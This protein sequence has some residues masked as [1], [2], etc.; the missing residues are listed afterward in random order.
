MSC[1]IISSAFSA[2]GTGTG[3]VSRADCLDDNKKWITVDRFGTLDS[4][5][6]VAGLGDLGALGV[7][8]KVETHQCDEA[9]VKDDFDEIETRNIELEY[10][11]ASLIKENE[12]L[13]LTYK[14]LFVSIS[15]SRVHRSIPGK[16]CIFQKRSSSWILSELNQGAGEVNVCDMQNW[17]SYKQ[18]IV[19]A[20]EEGFTPTTKAF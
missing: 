3:A 14:K 4:A 13:K 10:R 2:D 8:K 19:R 5:V 20:E 18:K 12:H 7:L 9:K 15:N 17:W 6:S 1:K 11:V 16:I